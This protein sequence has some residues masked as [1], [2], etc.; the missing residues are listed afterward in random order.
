MQTLSDF[1]THSR[2]E[3]ALSALGRRVAPISRDTFSAFEQE[4]EPWPLPWNGRAQVA[5]AMHWP[6]LQEDPAIWFLSLPL[7]EQGL[8]VPAARDAFLDRLL[9]LGMQPA[10]GPTPNDSTR[11]VLTQSNL[12]Q[13]NPLAFEPELHQR[14]LLHARLSRRFGQPSSAHSDL[15][16]RYLLGDSGLDWQ[17]LRLQGLA[18][19]VAAQDPAVIL[20]LTKRLKTLPRDVVLPMCYLMEHGDAPADLLPTL[21]EAMREARQRQDV[22]TFCALLRALLGSNDGRVGDWL[23]RIL[24]DEDLMAADCL[25]AIAARGWHHLEHE[26]RLGRFLERLASCSDANFRPVV[27]DLALIPRLRLPILMMLRQAPANSSLGRLVR[28][29]NT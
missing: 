27:H 12:M 25:A 13:D 20:A 16:R 18:D 10:D 17:M 26:T 28:E 7:D 19:E 8:L 5:C 15:A 21:W 22:E 6:A 14:A 23:D 2:A 11:D 1:F 24:D 3:L 9:T 29:G 4:R